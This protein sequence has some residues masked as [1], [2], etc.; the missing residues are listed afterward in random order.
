MSEMEDNVQNIKICE[1]D[2]GIICK[3]TEKGGVMEDE[4]A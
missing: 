2:D 4:Q 3:K 1:H